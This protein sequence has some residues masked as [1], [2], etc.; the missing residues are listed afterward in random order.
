MKQIVLIYMFVIH[1]GRRKLEDKITKE[2]G[3]THIRCSAVIF[4]N[5]IQIN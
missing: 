4:N 5:G 1:N 2:L 3:H